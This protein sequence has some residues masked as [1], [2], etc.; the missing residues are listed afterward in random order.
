M[1][2]GSLTCYLVRLLLS[3][4]IFSSFLLSFSNFVFLSFLSSVSFPF[5]DFLSSHIFYPFPS[6]PSAS[7][8]SYN[9]L[10]TEHLQST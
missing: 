10:D 7:F 6:I 5:S 2:L 1:L 9:R 8:A 4:C 3:V